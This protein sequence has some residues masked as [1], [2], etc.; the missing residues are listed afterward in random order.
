MVGLGVGRVAG[1]MVAARAVVVMVAVGW[2]AEMVAV[3]AAAAMVAGTVVAMVA[4][5]MVVS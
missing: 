1:E 3:M 5:A 4:V 2:V